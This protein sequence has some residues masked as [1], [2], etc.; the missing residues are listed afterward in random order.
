MGDVVAHMVETLSGNTQ[1]R[2]IDNPVILNF[3]HS[4]LARAIVRGKCPGFLAAEHDR[5]VFSPRQVDCVASANDRAQV[6]ERRAITC[7]AYNQGARF[8]LDPGGRCFRAG[9]EIPALQRE[10]C[11]DRWVERSAFL[12][13]KHGDRI[14]A[15]YSGN[16]IRGFIERT[17]RCSAWPI[18]Q[19]KGGR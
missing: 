8:A 15:Q 14:D 17:A 4:P 10:R 12:P 3:F 13:A 16:F 6:V 11:K 1:Q 7:L 19:P 2:F 9:K 18:K 5:A